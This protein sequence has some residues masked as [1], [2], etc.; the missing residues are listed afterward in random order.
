MWICLLPKKRHCNLGLVVFVTSREAFVAPPMAF[1]HRG[2]GVSWVSLPGL[3][4]APSNAHAGWHLGQSA[5]HFVLVGVVKSCGLCVRVRVSRSC[6]SENTYLLT[7]T[8][9]EALFKLSIVINHLRLT[10]NFRRVVGVFSLPFLIGMFFI[11][12]EIS[13][14]FLLLACSVAIHLVHATVNLLHFENIDQL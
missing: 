10:P 4:S 3:T 2:T 7:T 9:L 12:F 11:L 14:H 5:N 8:R 6:A 13:S 1:L